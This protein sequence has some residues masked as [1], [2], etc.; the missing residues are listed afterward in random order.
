MYKLDLHGYKIDKTT[1]VVDCFIYEHLLFG[2]KQ[3]EIITGDSRV[4][5]GVVK[6]VVENYGLECKPHIYN[7]H[8]LTI[9]L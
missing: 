8:T 3:L 4:V 6:E 9:T 5:K 7:P 1:E 2:S